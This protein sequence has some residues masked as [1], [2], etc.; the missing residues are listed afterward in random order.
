MRI[1]DA[2]KVTVVATAIAGGIALGAGAAYADGP[3]GDAPTPS[4]SPSVV[5][6]TPP[7]GDPDNS[8][9]D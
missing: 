9:W 5:Q 3:T 6:S 8:P 7:A 2:F 4:V 1:V